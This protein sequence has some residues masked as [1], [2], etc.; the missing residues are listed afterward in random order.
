MP[1]P[2][3]WLDHENCP[4]KADGYGWEQRPPST[5]DVPLY[6]ERMG[7]LDLPEWMR[8]PDGSCEVDYVSTMGCDRPN[9]YTTSLLS[10]VSQS[11]SPSLP[12]TETTPPAPSHQRPLCRFFARNGRCRF[13]DNCRFS[14][15]AAP[16]RTPSGH[17]QPPQQ[18]QQQ[19]LGGG[20]EGLS[21][22][23]IARRAREKREDE[24]GRRVR[25]CQFWRTEGTCKKG[26][27]C[28]NRHIDDD[29]TRH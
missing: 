1:R 8:A 16:P 28:T 29:G 18:Q 3:N 13:G 14:H 26:V 11:S 6:L 25:I 5:Y 19:L 23:L 27:H 7:M 17:H 21:W 2:A 24:E 20:D 9:V 12:V 15:D 22:E 4:A 10:P